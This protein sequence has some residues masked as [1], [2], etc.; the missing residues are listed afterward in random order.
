MKR[1]WEN[2]MRFGAWLGGTFAFL[3]TG[4]ALVFLLG[5][6]LMER[7]SAGSVLQSVWSLVPQGLRLTG[8]TV[9]TAAAAV[10]LSFPLAWALAAGIAFLLK[11]RWLH[12][13]RS[14]VSGVSAIPAVVFG[15]RCG[16]LC[17]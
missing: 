12:A 13:A 5:I 17:R 14:A 3:L 16:T 9:S 6:L 15:S 4:C 11:P 8:F 2:L 7:A 10:A 1:A